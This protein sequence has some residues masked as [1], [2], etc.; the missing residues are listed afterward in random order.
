MRIVV[1]LGGNA[2]LKRGEPLEAGMQRQ[3]IATAAR[4]LAPVA[5]RYQLVLTHGNGPQV[6]LLALQTAAHN[7]ASPYPLDVLGAQTEGMIG[8]EL[9]QALGNA[10]PGLCIATLLTQVEVDAQD[11]AFAAPSKPIGPVYT[12][13]AAKKLAAVRGWHVAADGPHWRRVVAS[14]LPKR[15]L[16]LGTIRILL[17]AGHTV[18]CAGGG[19][20]PVVQD[21]E[22]QFHGVEAVIDKDSSSALLAIALDADMLIM[23][24]DVPH[25]FTEFGSIATRAIKYASPGALRGYNFASGSMAP[26]I[27]A[28]IYMAEHG[29]CAAIGGLTDISDIIA[30][31]AGTWIEAEGA[32]QAICFYD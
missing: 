9:E 1:A 15:I 31:R 24:T 10:S 23:L 3:T 32:R 7:A 14:P 12:E 17:E 20:I 30:R 26:K 27:A 19:G 6:G 4:A 2:L 18:I 5:Q 8:Y 29:R 22:K 21:A 16:E 28:A 25:V 11:P 13:E